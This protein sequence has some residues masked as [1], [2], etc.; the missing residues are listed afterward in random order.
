MCAEA[1]QFYIA[2]EDP[3]FTPV[4][5]LGLIKRVYM[6]ELSPMRWLNRLF[7]KDIT[8]DDLHE[9]QPKVFDECTMCARCSMICPMGID[10]AELVHINREAMVA[11]ALIPSELDYMCR[12]QDNEGTIFGANRELLDFRLDEIKQ[13]YGVHIYIDKPDADVMMLTSGL[14]IHLFTDSMLGTI[15]TLEH[16]KINW[17]LCSHAFEAANFGFLAGADDTQKH[18]TLKIVDAAIEARVKMVLTPECGHTYPAMRWA[19]A[20]LYGKALSF[21]VMTV[22]EYFG[23]QIM[24]GKLTLKKIPG[25]KVVTLHDPCKVGRHGGVFEEARIIVKEL[26]LDLHETESNRELNFCCGG[27]GGNFLINSASPVRALG[28][29]NKMDEVSKTGAES[30]ILSCG[31]CRLNFEAGKIHSKETIEIDSIAALVGENLPDDTEPPSAEQ[32]I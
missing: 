1:C 20:E 27:G 23:R 25:D 29:K 22:S 24:D 7:V 8:L 19:A 26:G 28:Y 12:E 18:I 32:S 11:A 15:K 9:Y 13:K 16:M 3:K 30:L 5:K 31:S 2:S 14:D 17:T 6:R 21:E 10:I 4:S